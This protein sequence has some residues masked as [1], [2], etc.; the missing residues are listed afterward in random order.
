M[1][2]VLPRLV[3][4]L[5]MIAG[6]TP[7]DPVNKPAQQPANTNEFDAA[8]PAERFETGGDSCSS[9]GAKSCESGDPS[10]KPLLCENGSWR[11]QPACQEDQRCDLEPGET[12]GTCVKIAD[13]CI[14]R[15]PNTDFCE[16]EAVRFCSGGISRL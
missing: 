7:V 4:L 13:A 9:P 15:R 11:G 6:C 5:G 12:Y 2:P 1:T 3:W 16:A 8:V 14:G 10:R